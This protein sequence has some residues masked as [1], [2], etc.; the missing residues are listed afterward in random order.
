MYHAA[1][2]IQK[3]LKGF[4]VRK[5]MQRGDI[6]LYYMAKKVKASMVIKSLS[7]AIRDSF[8]YRQLTWQ[9]LQKSHINRCATV[10]Q[11]TW[12]G[13]QARKAEMP[14][15]KKMGSLRKLLLPVVIGWRIRHIFRTKE[16]H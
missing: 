12:R 7:Q 15:L 6:K 1:C 4:V 11:K 8:V 10:I 14:F 5:R 9:L 2:T 3:H 13:Y 16:V